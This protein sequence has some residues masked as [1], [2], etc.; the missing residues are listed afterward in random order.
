MNRGLEN[1]LLALF[2]TTR[3]DLEYSKF[4][5]SLSEVKRG[6][7]KIRQQRQAL[8]LPCEQINLLYRYVMAQGHQLHREIRKTLQM[9]EIDT[10]YV[11]KEIAELHNL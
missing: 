9:E 3:E 5:S 6:L 7:E 8:S 2:H 10:H 11:N 4:C 1:E